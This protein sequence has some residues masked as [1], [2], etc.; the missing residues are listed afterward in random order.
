MATDT[1]QDSS[2]ITANHRGALASTRRFIASIG[3][4]QWDLPT[5]CDGWNVRELV[6]HVIVGNWWAAELAGGHTVDEVGH[7]LDGDHTVPDPLNAY[8]AS[9]AAA[10][11]A[12][13]APGALEAPCAV[14]YGPVP[15]SLYA[16]H[17]FIDVLIHGWDIATAT[18]QTAT[19]D[20]QL[21][22]ACW[23]E[24]EPQLEQ[25]QGSTMFGTARGSTDDAD[26]T[27]R[28]LNALGRSRS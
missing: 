13:D 21:V 1:T 20:S 12:F 14:S 3:S 8:D 16:G 7:R 26:I 6:N 28:L 2:T 27:R 4:D 11:A 15:G 24:V 17:R 10:I 23:R 9:A 25:L 18:G 5:P 22:D 19:L